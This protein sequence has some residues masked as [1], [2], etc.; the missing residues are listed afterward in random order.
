MTVN[1]TVT[2]GV[3]PSAKKAAH[4]KYTIGH[5]IIKP[6]VHHQSFEQLWESKW[7][8]PVRYWLPS[9]LSNLDPDKSFLVHNGSLPV[10][11]RFRDGL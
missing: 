4:E 5:A 6:A 11:V 10:H 2:N 3:A 7:K 8:A 9:V 1:G